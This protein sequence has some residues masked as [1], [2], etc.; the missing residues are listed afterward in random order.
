[1]LGCNGTAP[2][3]YVIDGIDWVTANRVSPAIVNMSLG[4]G[5]PSELLDF[6]VNSSINSGLTY[7]VAAGNSGADACNVSPARVPNALTIGASDPSDNMAGWSN[8]G[9]CVDMFAPGVGILSAY[10]WSNTATNTIS[11]TSMA[12]PHV[13]GTAALFLESR[14]NATPA[15]VRSELMLRATPGAMTGVTGG[16]PNLMVYTAPLGPTAGNAMFEGRVVTNEGR[17]LKNVRVTLQN[18]TTGEYSVALTNPFG[19]FRFEELET[20]VTYVATV[21]NKRYFFE[22]SPYAFSLNDD[23]TDFAFVGTPR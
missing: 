17:G 6:V 8:F 21:N 18:G 5:V 9:S 15:D 12:T 11:G 1:V 23:F 4:T 16:S 22:N 10:S 14:P 2:V 19:Y 3:S 20:G 7:V 13:T